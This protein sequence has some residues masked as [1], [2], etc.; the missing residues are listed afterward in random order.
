MLVIRITLLITE[1]REMIQVNRQQ[2][3][4]FRTLLKNIIINLYQLKVV[5]SRRPFLFIFFVRVVKT[6]TI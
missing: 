6:S 3:L 1:S 5:T 2:L 4:F